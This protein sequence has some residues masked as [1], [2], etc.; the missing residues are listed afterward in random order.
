[1][2]WGGRSEGGVWW[3][4][5]RG[6]GRLLCVCSPEGY[7]FESTVWLRKYGMASK[8]RDGFGSTVWLL[9]H[10]WLDNTVCFESTVYFENAG[11]LRKYGMLDETAK[12]VKPWPEFFYVPRRGMGREGLASH[13]VSGEGR[14]TDK[15][16]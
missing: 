8:V 10:G 1:M 14:Q 13:R 2:V 15:F 9:K 3:A 5:D 11:W 6:S 4:V 16:R 12:V 7:G